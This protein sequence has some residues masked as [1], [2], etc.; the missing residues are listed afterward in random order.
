VP[1]LRSPLVIARHTPPPFKS[2]K[3]K[4]GRLLSKKEILERT[5][6]SYPTIWAW[7][8]LGLFPRSRVTGGRS[9]WIE[10]EY[11]EWLNALPP[12]RLKGDEEAA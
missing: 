9:S 3:P 7:M 4:S 2:K 6:V 11:E 5:G 12:V 8:R 10:S 1:K